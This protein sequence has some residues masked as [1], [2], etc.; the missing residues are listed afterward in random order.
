[1]SKELKQIAAVIPTANTLTLA[2]TVPVGGMSLAN[3]LITNPDMADARFSIAVVNETK[4]LHIAYSQILP[5]RTSFETSKFSL[6]SEDEV[7]VE[8]TNGTTNFLITGM[9]QSEI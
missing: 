8:S 6:E 4:E 2:Y 3:V 5:G 9:D 7:H 1:M